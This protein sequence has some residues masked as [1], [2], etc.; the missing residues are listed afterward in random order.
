MLNPEPGAQPQLPDWLEENQPPPRLRVNPGRRGTIALT[1]FGAVIA[2][3]AA[4]LVLGHPA[5]KA[6]VPVVS[7]VDVRPTTSVAA[8]PADIIVSVV[9][10]VTRPGL[11]TL[12]AGARVA[13]AVSAA[14]GANPHDLGSVNL[15]QHL[16]DGDQVVVGGA[17]APTS[18]SHG[19]VNLNTATVN[20]LDVLP[21][22]GPVTAA[23]IIDYRK[24][25]G[26]FTSVDEL[27]HIDGIGPSRL[28]KL[29]SLVTV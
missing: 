9:G 28:E 19:P 7:A 22:V 13:D 27:S 17:A 3:V 25:K 18:A 24:Q 15:A 4:A 5:A 6:P 14:G 10:A 16:N 8:P 23:A 21:G 11:V 1:V 20:D 2:A 12:R 29:R 26:R